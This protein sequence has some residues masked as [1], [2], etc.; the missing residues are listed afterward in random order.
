VRGIC[1]AL[2]TSRHELLEL[3]RLEIHLAA[4]FIVA[5]AEPTVD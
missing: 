2:A 3:P 1:D 5:A 4:S